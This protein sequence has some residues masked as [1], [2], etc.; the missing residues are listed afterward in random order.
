LS[1]RTSFLESNIKYFFSIFCEENQNEKS[2]FSFFKSVLEKNKFL[3]LKRKARAPA[4]SMW[5]ERKE[6]AGVRA[7]KL[8]PSETCEKKEGKMNDGKKG[9]G[10]EEA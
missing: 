4:G 9:K 8:V 6:E 5:R 1:P 7:R 10:G 2:Y 3:K